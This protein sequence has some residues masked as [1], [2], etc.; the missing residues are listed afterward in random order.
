MGDFNSF[1]QKAGDS[2]NLS[3]LGDKV[4]TIT[5]V[6]SSPY[7]NGEE[8]T[9]G[10][11]ITTKESWEKADGQ[12]VNKVHTTRK[13]IVSMLLNDDFQSALAKGE[14]FRVKCPAEKIKSKSGGMG[15]YTLVSAE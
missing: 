1:N 5:A 12:K 2:I 15:Y 13:A 6:E 14:T 8:Q 11:K 3:E 9:D 7:I 4:F 10:V